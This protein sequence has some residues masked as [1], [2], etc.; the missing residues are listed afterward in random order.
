MLFIVLSHWGGHGS[1][2]EVNYS[3][4]LNSA[5]LQYTQYLGELGN[6]SFV[7][8]TGYF[9][10]TREAFKWGG[11]KRVVVDVKLYVLLIWTILLLCGLIPFSWKSLLKA[12]FPIVFRQYWFVIPYLFVVLSST[13]INRLLK[14]KT[15]LLLWFLV[16]TIVGTSLFLLDVFYYLKFIWIF[17]I[18]YSIGAL[19]RI[20]KWDEKMVKRSF[21]WDIILMSSI[22]LSFLYI[23]GSDILLDKYSID[24]VPKSSLFWRYNPAPILGGLG[25]F[26]CFSRRE[27]Q[28]DVINTIAKSTFAVYLI[29]ENPNIHPL[30]WKLPVF[31]N[32]C[33]ID[34]SFLFPLSLLICMGIMA[35]CIVIDCTIS[36]IRSHIRR[37]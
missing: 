5:Y 24:F 30:L 23:I 11:V 1:W 6:F 4:L 20:Y 13:F 37:F 33:F 9:L 19:V 10:S 27:F 14:D 18:W 28:S 25:L 21:I 8:I 7:L 2:T 3:N 35:I 22:W 36:R 31:D 12:S 15:Y 29:S 17:S 16:L 32:V 26:F 34:S